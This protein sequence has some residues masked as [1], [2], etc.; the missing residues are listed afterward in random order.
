MTESISLTLTNNESSRFLIR[1]RLLSILQAF[2][3]DACRCDIHMLRI[4]EFVRITLADI[5][6]FTLS[7]ELDDDSLKVI[8]ASSELDP[9]TC[10]FPACVHTFQREKAIGVSIPSL[11]PLSDEIL[12]QLTQFL[13]KPSRD[14]LMSELKAK[15]QELAVHQ[16][17]LEKE[18]E[19]RTSDLKASEELSR[20]IIDGAPSSVAIVDES[21]SISL[22]NSTAQNVYGYSSE[23]ATGENILT[24]L[25]MSLP[26]A[27]S[28]VLSAPL[29]LQNQPDVEGGFF[30]V[31]TT[32][33][34]GHMVPIDL[35]VSI[36]ELNGACHAALFLRDVT[37]R[38]A[39]EKELNDAKAKAEEAV[40]VKSMFL[41]NMSH[42]IRTPMNAIIG[43]SHLALKTDLT[44]KQHD[45]V[46]K[47]HSSATLLLGII[48][49]ILDFSKIEAGKLSIETT[50]FYL[51]DVFHNVSMVTGQKAFEKGLE[52]IFDLPRET[53]RCL[54]GDPLRLGQIIINL[55]N[56]SVK[57]TEKGEI[58]VS[59]HHIRNVE[60][61]VELEFRISDTGIGMTDKQMKSL[62]TAF[63]QADG[64]TT[65]KYGGTG[66]G[67]SICRRLVE[68]MG[69]QIRVESEA[70]KGSHF[71]FN[72]LVKADPANS[73]APSIVP[74]SLE[75]IRILVVDDNEHALEIMQEMLSTLPGKVALANSGQQAVDCIRKAS[76]QREKFDLIFMD[77]NMPEMDGIETSR[78]IRESF[79]SEYQPQIVI[80]TAYDKE[81]VLDATNDLDI[82]GFL[83]KPVGQSYLFDLL[84]ELFGRDRNPTTQIRKK[85][86][87]TH[88]SKN[89]LKGLKVLL[90]EDN[91]INQ[92]IA[93]E[94]MEGNGLLVTVANNGQEALE[95]LEAM[96][97]GES[98]FDIV[99]MDLQMPVM[100]GYEASHRIRA[101]SSYDTIPLIAMT[102][103][104]MV[105]ER[106][107]CLNLG[108]NDH[109][110]KPIDPEI[111]FN[112]IRKWCPRT[113]NEKD[114]SPVDVE[115]SQTQQLDS[116]IESAATPKST[117]RLTAEKRTL[118]TLESLDYKNGLLR[119]AGNQTLYRRLL[120]QLMDKE[121]SAPER[122]T[123]AL[124]KQ[125]TEQAIIIAH[126]LKGS[127]SN[128]GAIRLSD[129]ASRLEVAIQHGKER[130][131]ID[132]LNKELDGYLEHFFQD[133]ALA[134][135]RPKP[136][137]DKRL[138]LKDEELMIIHTLDSLLDSLDAY[139]IEFLDEHYVLLNTL[140]KSEDFEACCRCVNDCDFESASKSLRKAVSIY[141]LDLGKLSGEKNGR[142]S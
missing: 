84:V 70:G 126:S 6:R 59:V 31:E 93:V 98:H 82:A 86:L 7:F 85:E 102:A 26:D 80:V 138:E 109:I 122:L 5:Q 75:K 83:S 137:S 60:D 27:L 62:F 88:D 142:E 111:L 66:L 127:A 65:R 128:L 44:P 36:F 119:V 35:G 12:N 136:S 49:D 118:E 30:E 10:S 124:D 28:H 33:K 48:N 15:N 17:G 56:N 69:G 71:I 1:Q 46:S 121:I 81:D 139:A 32:T 141:P 87:P 58:T 23:E 101:N 100:D 16:A 104:A 34:E 125:D 13:A 113:L 21:L 14:E 134:L 68:L 95:H 18:I 25:N 77:W 42:E 74:Q 43:M 29:A 106:E 39:V 117:E 129:I 2:G 89:D 130:A 110:S 112:T 92:Q 67:L 22:W 116:S 120:S 96:A 90:T 73:S 53:P 24:L 105:E 45:Y 51:D 8:L 55:V 140:L 99:F 133:L 132:K 40:E 41:A 9:Q 4:G 3:Y 54:L 20:T 131:E 52:L 135:G 103:H 76:E 63:T 78:L 47:I 97:K 115:Q 114:E 57:F 123:I 50:E 72:V 19:L 91:E 37:S 107:R 11:I 79:A 38:K 64:S 94:L 61:L 108:M